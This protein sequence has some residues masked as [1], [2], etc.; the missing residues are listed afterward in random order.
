MLITKESVLNLKERTLYIRQ[1]NTNIPFC[2][3]LQGAFIN[4]L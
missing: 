3:R 4:C 2:S 1:S